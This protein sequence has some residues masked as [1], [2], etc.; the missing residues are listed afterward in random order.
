MMN[1]SAA[2]EGEG[3]NLSRFAGEVEVRSTEGEGAANRTVYLRA[4]STVRFAANSTVRFAALS[5]GAARRPL[6]LRGRG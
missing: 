3:R 6:P 1:V 2:G 4:N 5:P